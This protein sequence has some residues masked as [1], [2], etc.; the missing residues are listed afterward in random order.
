MLKFQNVLNGRFYYISV[1]RH[2]TR[3]Y[4]LNIIYG[5]KRVSRNRQLVFNSNLALIQEIRRLTKRRISH[6]YRLIK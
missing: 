5:G 3:P 4:T 1:Q 6:G 2:P